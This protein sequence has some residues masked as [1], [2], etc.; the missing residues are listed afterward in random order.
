VAAHGDDPFRAQVPRRQHGEEADR[1][2]TDHRDGLAR[3]DLGGLG[4]EPGGAEHVGGGEE[5]RDQVCRGQVGG[6]H[7]G[8]VGQRNAEGLGLGAKD[9]DRLAVD[10][11]ALVAGP[12]D[13]AGVVRG[14]ERADHELAG[15][16]RRDL[17]PDLFDDTGVL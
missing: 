7:E 12:A 16:D 5:T 1:A 10:A 3:S 8:A 4:A 9:S 17:S 6:G 15:L 2:V 11:R 14:E 13:L